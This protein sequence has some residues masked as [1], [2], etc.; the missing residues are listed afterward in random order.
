MCESPESSPDEI[1]TRAGI[2]DKTLASNAQFTTCIRF[3][4]NTDIEENIIYLFS[5]LLSEMQSY[6]ESFALYPCTEWEAATG[7]GIQDKTLA[8]NLHFWTQPR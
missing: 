1:T 2:Q 8:S 7:A 4:Q 3:S 6:S 5:E